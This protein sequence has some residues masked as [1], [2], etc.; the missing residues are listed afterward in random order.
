M[1]LHARD[2]SHALPWR[3]CSPSK[4]QKSHALPQMLGEAC[5]GNPATVHGD[6]A[7]QSG[8]E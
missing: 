8:Q 3:S 1:A 4:Y 5:M 6:N 7:M 2:P